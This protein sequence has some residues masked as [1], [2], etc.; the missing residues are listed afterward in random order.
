MSG[1]ATFPS[2]SALAALTLADNTGWGDFLNGVTPN[3]Q[4]VSEAI[5]D[6]ALDKTGDTITGD[7]LFS[8]ASK[9]QF[10]QV[11]EY[12]HSGAVGYLDAYAATAT[13]FL[14]GK[15]TIGTQTPLAALTVISVLDGLNGQI[16]VR[17]SNNDAS[18]IVW[19]N[20]ATG[21]AAGSRT[22]QIATNYYSVTGNLDILRSTTSTGD[23]TTYVASFKSDGNFFLPTTAQ[24]Q[25]RDTG[26]YIYS[27]TANHLDQ[28]GR[29][30][31]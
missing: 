30:H 1:Q 9:A 11:T 19:R 12:W 26:S 15:V 5:D 24:I 17:S 27:A 3:L 22:W 28:I 13:R 16:T 7:V 4:A 18:S 25:F 21:A 10:R 20:L 23:P 6:R 31:V 14:S 2:E 8:G 29:A